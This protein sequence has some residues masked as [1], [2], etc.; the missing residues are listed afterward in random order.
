LAASE[1]KIYCGRSKAFALQWRQGGLSGPPIN[2]TGAVF[3][4]IRTTLPKAPDIIVVDEVQGKYELLFSEDCTKGLS[5]ANNSTR[6]VTLA[7]T[8]GGDPSHSPD[9]LTLQVVIL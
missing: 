6:S 9:P 7:L 2:A 8:F 3:S 4:V 1:I 5:A